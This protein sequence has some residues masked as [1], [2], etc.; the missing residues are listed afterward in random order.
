MVNLIAEIVPDWCSI[1]DGSSNQQSPK[2]S[3]DKG[4]WLKID[5]KY[6]IGVVKQKIAAA[7]FLKTPL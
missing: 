1:V 3:G 5:K 7:S 4:D 2:K 6:N